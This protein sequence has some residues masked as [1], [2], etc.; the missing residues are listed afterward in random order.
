MEPEV[1]FLK[2]DFLMKCGVI[3]DQEVLSFF[4]IR[5]LPHRSEIVLGVL[6]VILRCDPVSGQS[7]GASQDQIALIVFLCVLRVPRLRAGRPGGFVSPGGLGCSRHCGGHNFRIWARLRYRRFRF[8]NVFHV[9]PW[10]APAGRAA[11]D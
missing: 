2:R 9:G 1:D 5:I 10:A 4:S 11:F 8:R 3:A 7:F 6:E